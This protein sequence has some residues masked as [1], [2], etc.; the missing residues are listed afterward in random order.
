MDL[1]SATA[2]TIAI[3]YS[4]ELVHKLDEKY[5][6]DTIARVSD[7]FGAMEASY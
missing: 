6:P 4:G 7:I 2:C 1:Q 5:I 3:H